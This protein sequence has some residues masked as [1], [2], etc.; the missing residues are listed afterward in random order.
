MVYDWLV[1][2]L[3]LR[4]N[5]EGIAFMVST[6]INGNISAQDGLESSPTG[7]SEDFKRRM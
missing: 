5:E 2:G 7:G 1:F 4:L 3:F 6:A